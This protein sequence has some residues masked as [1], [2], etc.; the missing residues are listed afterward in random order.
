MELKGLEKSLEEGCR[1]HGFRSGGGLRVIRL[2]HEGNLRGYGEHP[3]VEDAL[4]HASEDFLASGRKYSEVYGKSKPHYLTGSQNVTSPLDG[5]L[6]QGKTIDAFMQGGEVVVE[7]RGLAQTKSPKD[8]I[9]KVR[10]TGQ[11]VAWQN[12]GYTFE[13]RLDKFPSGVPCYSISILESPEGRN[14]ADPWMYNIVK[15]GKA[16]GFFEALGK[17][18]EAPELEVT[19]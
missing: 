16:K 7:L 9:E 18:I 2:E 5:W 17:A 12:R 3:N 19:K 15:T 1:L 4:S 13:T 10:Q 11:P 6:I 8:I 14:T